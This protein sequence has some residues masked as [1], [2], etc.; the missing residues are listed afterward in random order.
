MIAYV[1]NLASVRPG[2]APMQKPDPKVPKNM[3]FDADG[4]LETEGATT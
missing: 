4:K 3:Q 2:A 1:F